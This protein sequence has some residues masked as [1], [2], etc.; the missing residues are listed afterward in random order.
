MDMQ[1]LVDGWGA[2]MQR[3]RAQSQMTLG[4]LIERLESFCADSKVERIA[5]PHSYRGYY[6]DLAFERGDGLM[7]ASDAVKLAR[8]ALGEVFEGYK[9]GEYQMGKL[10][11]VWLAEYG[12]SGQKIVAVRDDGT[13]KVADD[14]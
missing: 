6:C 8:S 11:P 12:C 2:R 3:D 9:G 13:F 10:T 4:Q 7:L 5:A 14:D 1:D